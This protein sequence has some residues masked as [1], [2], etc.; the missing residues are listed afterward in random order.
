M[1][2]KIKEGISKLNCENSLQYFSIDTKDSLP[3]Q[4]IDNQN[5]SGNNTDQN[6]QSNQIKIVTRKK[7][8]TRVYIEI[9]GMCLFL[10]GIYIGYTISFTS[11]DH[12][13]VQDIALN[14]LIMGCS[15]FFAN[16]FIFLYNHRFKRNSTLKIY[17]IIISCKSIYV[18]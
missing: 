13:G 8:K 16:L 7:S 1:S 4:L 3:E 5:N 10:S 12:L 15:E 18:Y 11:L 17:N 9:A 2:V 14:S 6:T